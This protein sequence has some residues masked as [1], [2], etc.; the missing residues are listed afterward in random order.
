MQACILQSW[1]LVALGLVLVVFL[2]GFHLLEVSVLQ[3]NS[4]ILLCIFLEREQEL[5][6]KAAPFFLDCSS[7]HQHLFEPALCNSG[8]VMAE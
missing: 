3:K 4:K 5:R 7:L 6:L 8:K 1:C 2:S